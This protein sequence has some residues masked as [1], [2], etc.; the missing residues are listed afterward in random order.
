MK[1]GYQGYKAEAM[2]DEEPARPGR[3]LLLALMTAV[4]LVVY[5]CVLYDTQVIHHEEYLDKSAGSIVRYETVKS[6]RGIVTDRN[7]EV[8]IS[9]GHAYDLTFDAALL[10]RDEDANE[11]IL[12]LLWLCHDNGVEWNDGLPIDWEEP[13][14]FTIDGGPTEDKKRLLWCLNSIRES[15]IRLE[16]YLLER[17]ELVDASDLYELNPEDNYDNGELFEP[18][19]EPEVNL[20]VGQKAKNLIKGVLNRGSNKNSD[21]TG[22]VI[23]G[24][25][26]L[27]RFSAS[28]LSVEILDGAGISAGDFLSWLGRECGIPEEF[29][30]QDRRMV[31]GIQYELRLRRYGDNSVYLLAQDIDTEFIS[32]LSD[33]NYSGYKVVNS[34]V[35]Q[36]ETDA[37]AHI[38]GTV[39]PLYQTD[40]GNPLYEGYSLDAIVGKDGVEAAFENYLHGQDGRR[41]L[42]VTEDGKITG[43]YYTREPKPG[44]TVELTIDLE[45]QKAT[46]AALAETVE[47]MD[48]AD[49]DWTRGAGVAVVRVGTG[50]ILSLASYPSFDITAY[51]RD[52]N[53]LAADPAKPLINRATMGLYAPGSTLKPATAYAALTS[54]A[55]SLKGRISD[56][57]TWWYPRTNLYA[58]CWYHAG[59]GS[60]NITQAITNSC[61][62]FF[63]ELGYRMGMDTLDEYYKIL[64]LG[65]HTGIEIGDYAGNR[66]YNPQGQDQAPWAAFGQSNQRYTPLQ[67]AN[68]IA[69]IVS[70]GRHCPAHLL[71]AVKG[72][73]NA[74]LIAQGD[75]TPMN[76]VEIAPEYLN[77]IKTGMKNL[78]EGGL[79]RYFQDCVVDAGAKTGTAQLGRG[80]TNNGVFICFAPY[81]EPEVAIGMVIERGSAGA[82]LAST[83][84]KILNA[85]FDRE[86]EAVVITGEN[87]LLP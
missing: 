26:L 80:I 85:W 24:S 65:E 11:A 18:E 10:K 13:F 32:Q 28:D 2:R 76:E 75:T 63:A 60:Q 25:D 39:G 64:G 79:N 31:L 83:A 8:L 46:E 12:R 58:N 74:N 59:H 66:P 19:P 14:K 22:P 51:R 35:R 5:T 50:E 7:G 87:E 3:L 61:N 33:G 44:N 49:R 42:S 38:L 53:N 48:A 70:G 30:G 27:A 15:R 54:G 37:A 41:I 62:Y 45:F 6:S 73:G 23:T 36:Y 21:D 68:Y 20:T 77:A 16:N 29:S 52:Y 69:T 40:L 84:V 56:T 47:R 71:K 17:P 67:L 4:V 43:E 82:N 72:Y 57:G 78:A 55:I 1:Y 81:D 86:P 34:T 9:N